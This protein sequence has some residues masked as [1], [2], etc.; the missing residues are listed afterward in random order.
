MGCGRGL[1]ATG[2]ATQQRR[3][4]TNPTTRQNPPW[5]CDGANAVDSVLLGAR[6]DPKMPD[7]GFALQS[8]SAPASDDEAVVGVEREHLRYSSSSSGHAAPSDD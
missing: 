7:P 8:L 2:A 6:L 4:A 1:R 5:P 3:D